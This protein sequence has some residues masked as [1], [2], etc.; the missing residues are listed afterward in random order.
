MNT[1][2]FSYTEEAFLLSSLHE[3]VKVWARGS[4]QASFD[5]RIN[6]G[7]AELNLGFQLGHPASLHCDHPP[8]Q[9]PGPPPCPHHEAHGQ[10]P[11]HPRHRRRNRGPARRKRNRLCAEMH[12]F[13]HPKKAAAPAVLLPFTG[14]LLPVNVEKVLSAPETTPANAPAVTLTPQAAQPIQATA[15]VKPSKS[16]QASPKFIDSNVVK[17]QLFHTDPHRQDPL[18]AL[19]KKSYKAKEEDLWTRLFS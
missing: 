13:H 15:A 8:P 2:T 10:V 7:I 16:S 12:N 19:V 9:P 14:K 1:T 17:K 11:D 4:G 5:L 18:P 6:S 3:V